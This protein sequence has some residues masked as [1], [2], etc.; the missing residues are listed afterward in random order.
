M[1]G[2]GLQ[3]LRFSVFLLGIFLF[4]SVGA[5]AQSAGETSDHRPV[6]TVFG[7]TGLWHVFS[8]DNLAHGQA[9]INVFYDRINRNPGYLTISGVGI[10][11]AVGLT[12]WLEFGASVDINEHILVGRATQLSFGQQ[13]LGFFG[14]KT[15]GAS[16]FAN[17][18]VP[19]SIIMPQLRFPATPTGLFNGTGGYYNNLPFAGGTRESN[20]IG[21]VN[22]G[23]KMNILSESRGDSFGFAIRG[24]VSVP[25]RRSVD[26]RLGSPRQTGEWQY[27]SD[28][29]LSK[30]IGEIAELDWNAGFRG[31]NS[32]G[33]GSM[34]VL[35]DEVPLGFG[36][37]LPRKTRIQLMGELTADVFVG[38]HTPVTTFGARD[39]ID[40]TAGFRAFLTNALSLSAGYRRPLNQFGGDKNGFV[41]D[42]S[43]TSPGPKNLL[44]SPPSLTC[45]AD[46]TDFLA[47]QLVTLAA[48][49]VSSNGASL[50]YEWTTTGGTLDGA[51]GPTV[52]LKTDNLAPGAYTATVRATE[53]PG[54]F[55]DCTTRFTV[56]TPPPPALPPTVSCSA[57]RTRVQVGEIVNITAQ[58][59]SPQDRPLTYEWTTSGGRVEGS[60]ATVRFDTTRLAAGSYTLRVR[61]TDD[62]NL[63]A[64]CSVEIVVTTPPPPPPP[65]PVPQ[66]S[67][68]NEC[69]FKLNSARVDNVCK[70]KLDDAALRLR[71]ESDSTLVIVGFAASTERRAPQLADSRAS[72]TRTYL[73]KEKGIAESRIQVQRG[74][75][76]RGA[77]LRRVD[78]HLVPRGATFSGENL[79]PQRPDPEKA[80]SSLAG[81]GTP[82]GA[83]K[84]TARITDSGR[85]VIASAR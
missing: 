9:G 51:T 18:F 24:Y 12:D 1:R 81:S 11:G 84:E 50:T 21:P 69:S 45:S 83:T 53:R 42:L 17:Q 7:N 36:I 20:G 56:R 54:S 58:A 66:A 63:S 3:I 5:Q 55:A 71:N 59:G 82:G 67:K 57:D 38:A 72:N 26:V 33:D 32:P 4:I 2:T 44:P 10:S 6:A 43:Y 60:G 29:I 14:N 37:V 30:N 48:Q 28:L 65:P 49:G 73:V 23:L 80:P 68:L 19:G 22:F 52:H 27:G 15:P 40:A 16:P 46:P 41:A 34:V 78:I 13:A 47:G 61:V 85:I 74:A 70:A 62:R 8:A 25:T 39:P 75:P 31:I 64:E 77:E 79:L 35:S 76:G